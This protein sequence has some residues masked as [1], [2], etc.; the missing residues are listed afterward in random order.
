L[1][2]QANVLI[3]PHVGGMS[4]VYLQQAYP[5]VRTNLQ[6]FLAGQPDAMINVV[7]H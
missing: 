5:I 6:H 4:N 3:T 1:W 2:Q 7:P